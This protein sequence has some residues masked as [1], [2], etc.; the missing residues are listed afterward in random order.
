MPEIRRFLTVSASHL[1]QKFAE[2]YLPGLIEEGYGS[3]LAGRY[4]FLV[5]A[6]SERCD[7]PEAVRKL[8]AYAAAELDCSYVLFDSDG[9][10]L[11]GFATYDDGDA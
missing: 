10:E 8:L 3:V 9:E 4:G 1:P 11:D 5:F 6:R 2:D 7:F